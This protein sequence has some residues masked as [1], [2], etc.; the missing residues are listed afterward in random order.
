MKRG[1]ALPCPHANPAEMK[2]YKEAG[3]RE[4]SHVENNSKCL[5]PFPREKRLDDLSPIIIDMIFSMVK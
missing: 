1:W 4:V 3:S 5:V 2:Q